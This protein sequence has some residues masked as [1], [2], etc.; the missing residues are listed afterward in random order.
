MRTATITRNT[1]E[2]KISLTLK[3]EGTGR[4]RIHTG[5]GFFDHMLELFCRQGRFDLTLSCAG[6]TQVD[7][8][9]TVEDVGIALG[10]AFDEALGDRAGITRYG[11]IA[12]PMDEALILAATDICGRPTLNFDLAFDAPRVGDFDTELVEEFFLAFVRE[13]RCSLHL[14]K[15]A[16]KNT[17]HIA[18]GCFKAFGRI[19]GTA[20]AIDERLAGEIPSTKGTIL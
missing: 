14:V 8:H 6:D 9:H 11:D 17:H 18:E 4:Y 15:L 5:C 7:Y 19:L 16:G 20:A 3:L 12:L 1:N 10:R 2:T 13:L